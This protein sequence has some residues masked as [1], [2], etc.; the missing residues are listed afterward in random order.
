LINIGVF[1]YQAN[2]PTAMGNSFVMNYGFLP[3]EI[4]QLSNLPGSTAVSPFVSLITTM[5]LHGGFA[6]I[7]GNMWYLWIF[8]DNIEHH[9]GPFAFLVFYLVTGIA[10][11]L[12]H[13]IV[14][15]LGNIPLVGASGALSGVLGAY[16]LVHP[17]NRI[18]TLVP[19][20]FF[21]TTVRIPAFFFLAIWIAI[22]FFGI[23]DPNAPVAYGAHIGG[24]IAGILLML[25]FGSSAKK[26]PRR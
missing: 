3:A 4:W 18:L 22:Q 14:T 13:S 6:H 24:F 9:L 8:G 1:I 12:A 21:L 20:G 19:I 7:I 23:L 16:M 2:L 26:T 10:A 15:P 5:F 25:V 11:T 17:K